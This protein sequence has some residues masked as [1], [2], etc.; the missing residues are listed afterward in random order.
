M[1]VNLLRIWV[2]SLTGFCTL[3]SIQFLFLSNKEEKA[4][5]YLSKFSTILR[6]TLNNS[7]KTHV[8][9]QEELVNLQN[10]VDIEKIRKITTKLYL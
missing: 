7:D 2:V 9:L 3:N 1:V 8:S 10:Y 4:Q 6:K 5:D